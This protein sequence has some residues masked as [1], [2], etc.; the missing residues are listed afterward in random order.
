MWVSTLIILTITIPGKA[1][2][3]EW[4][5]AAVFS[6][7]F[8]LMLL[9]PSSSTVSMCFVSLPLGLLVF[10]FAFYQITKHKPE[11]SWTRGLITIPDTVLSLGEFRLFDKES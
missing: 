9:I 10:N 7:Y 2:E 11:P 4:S 3:E 1:E 6:H 5:P 8:H